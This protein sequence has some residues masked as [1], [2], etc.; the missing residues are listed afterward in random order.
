MKEKIIAQGAEAILTKKGN[1][2]TKDRIKKGYRNEILDKSLRFKRTKHE[3]RI[4]EKASK[5]IPVPKILKTDDFQIEMEFIEGK[6]LSDYLDNAPQAEQIGICKQIGK[7][8]SKLHENHIIHGDLTT[9]NMIWVNQIG[10]IKKQGAE[11]NLKRTNQHKIPNKYNNSKLYFID[12][13]LSFHSQRIEDKAVD[14]HL[15]KQALE[16]KHFKN[17]EF[18]LK[19]CLK[20]YRWSK[21]QAVIK[22]LEKVESRGRYKGKH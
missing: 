1:I 5:F 11:Y 19:E 15:L 4:I 16:S 7:N 12:F 13:G 3:S 2:L 8:I 6:K 21:S 20:N 14:L 22:Q 18:L 9:S 10:H 17:Y